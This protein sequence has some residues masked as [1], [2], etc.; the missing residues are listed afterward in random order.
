MD[1]IGKVTNDI[2]GE[3]IK[4]YQQFLNESCKIRFQWFVDK[5]SKKMQ[6]RDLNGPEKTRL[7]KNIDI[8]T[9]SLPFFGK[10]GRNPETLEDVF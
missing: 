1:G 8:A 4:T 5:E 9:C 10:K 3:T 2:N 7:F 6:W